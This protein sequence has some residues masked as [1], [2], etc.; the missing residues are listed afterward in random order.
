MFD[1][2]QK[3]FQSKAERYPQATGADVAE[4]LLRAAL[5]SIP[6]YGGSINELL[7]LVLEPAVSRRREQWLKGLADS[8]ETIQS[9]V[10][11]LRF[12]GFATERVLYLGSV[13]GNESGAVHSSSGKTN[14]FA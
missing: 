4:G 14:S 11:G 12:A 13:P 8:I 3:L 2:P 10:G 7:S 9:G 6:K 1:P 5:A